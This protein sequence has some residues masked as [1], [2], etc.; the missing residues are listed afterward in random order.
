MASVAQ[1]VEHQPKHQSILGLIPG[2]GYIPEL[3]VRSLAQVG[4]NQSMCLFHIDVFLSLP[5]APSL[6]LSLKIDG[7]KYPQVRINEKKNN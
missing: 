1:W 4:G 3:Q 2:Q 7:K 6:P 5:L